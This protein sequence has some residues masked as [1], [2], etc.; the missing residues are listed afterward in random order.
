MK[1]RLLT[2]DNKY[3]YFHLFFQVLYGVVLLLVDRVRGYPL[4]VLFVVSER[5]L[6]CNTRCWL[7][8]YSPFKSPS[9]GT[10]SAFVTEY[11][12][13]NPVSDCPCVSPT[14]KL[15]PA[16]NWPNVRNCLS[17]LIDGQLETFFA[18]IQHHSINAKS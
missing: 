10:A 11:S 4:S 14:L 2:G 6:V 18:N 9:I 15:I 7:T 5:I 3:Y 1:E 12:R 8:E 16:P 13:K 17:L